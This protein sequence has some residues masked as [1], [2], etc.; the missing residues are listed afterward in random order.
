MRH[1]LRALLRLRASFL[2]ILWCPIEPV[3]IEL[4]LECD[5]TDD[6]DVLKR[7]RVRAPTPDQELCVHVNELRASDAA[8]D[9]IR[10][11]M[12]CN[13]ISERALKCTLDI[14]TGSQGILSHDLLHEMRSATTQR[15]LALWEESFQRFP[16]LCHDALAFLVRTHCLPDC[17]TYN[18]PLLRKVL[19]CMEKNHRRFTLDA[20][21]VRACFQPHAALVTDAKLL[22][23]FVARADVTYGAVTQALVLA[24][25]QANADADAASNPLAL[26]ILIAHA[27]AHDAIVLALAQMF[28]RHHEMH[29]VPELLREL[30]NSSVRLD[31]GAGSCALEAVMYFSW[32]SSWTKS[33][34][35]KRVMRRSV[36]LMLDLGAT[37]SPQVL[38]APYWAVDWQVAR[39]IYAHERTD[40]ALRNHIRH[41]WCLWA[42]SCRKFMTHELWDAA[43][44]TATAFRLKAEA[45]ASAKKSVVGW[46]E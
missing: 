18:R 4:A 25:P 36:Q 24:F 17:R 12:R 23:L 40:A 35:M 5:E 32:D 21:L 26:R 46:W 15:Q 38:A 6:C 14:F 33:V 9:R 31:T 39:I 42:G 45:G 30:M 43:L 29:L 2:N 22:A 8:C 44:A 20:E 41:S 37:V 19:Q 1:Q 27:S 34:Q 28:Q 11:L 13:R 7:A 16:D 10:A 3:T